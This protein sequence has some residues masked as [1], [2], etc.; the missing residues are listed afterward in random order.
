[1]A[2]A[3]DG[4]VKLVVGCKQ[5]VFYEKKSLLVGASPHFET[6][7]QGDMACNEKNTQTV[8]LPNVHPACFQQLRAFV[9]HGG[10]DERQTVLKK[11]IEGLAEAAGSLTVPAT[12]Q[13][14]TKTGLLHLYQMTN[15]LLM[16]EHS[17][18]ILGQIMH[19]LQ[20]LQDPS[21]Y[22]DGI[23]SFLL[24]EKPSLKET[25]P[26]R[27]TIIN[28]VKERVAKQD[29]QDVQKIMLELAPTWWNEI[30]TELEDQALDMSR[31]VGELSGQIREFGQRANK[32]RSQQMDHNRVMEI[33]KGD[34]LH[35]MRTNM[36]KLKTAFFERMDG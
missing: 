8:E 16:E 23:V 31:R 26:M 2:H 28:F 35:A 9:Y 11:Y 7:L 32:R 36:K 15:S 29:S 4:L 33:Q 17:N 30:M 18:L 27:S 14:E 12:D 21:E 1:M 10:D 3:D 25:E 13:S 34:E 24:R 6:M 22:P 5:E 19:Q 20:Q